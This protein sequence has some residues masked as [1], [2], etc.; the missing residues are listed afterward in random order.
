MAVQES[1]RPQPVKTTDQRRPVRQALAATAA[2]LG[3]LAG[4]VAAGAALSGTWSV[5]AAW[6]RAALSLFEDGSS[7]DFARDLLEAEL[8]SAAVGESLF[9]LP[10]RDLLETAAAFEGVGVEGVT[11]VE[12]GF[13]AWI[14]GGEEAVRQTA[15][16]LR[17]MAA[18]GEVRLED[19]PEDPG[20]T[21]LY[22]LTAGAEE[23][24]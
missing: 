8:D 2:S 1:L 5:S 18:Y 9:F 14:S 21:R 13:M 10:V 15:E 17:Q 4:V 16:R 3:L 6:N 11:L 7:A 23:E 19:D 12:G 24:E 20:I 22:C